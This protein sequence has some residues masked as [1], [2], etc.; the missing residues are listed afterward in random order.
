[1]FVHLTTTQE[2]CIVNTVITEKL[3]LFSEQTDFVVVISSHW[4]SLESYWTTKYLKKI[5]LVC[6]FSSNWKESQF[7]ISKL[8]GT[9]KDH[10]VAPHRTAQKPSDDNSLSHILLQKASVSNWRCKA[11]LRQHRHPH[12]RLVQRS[13]SSAVA[14]WKEKSKVGAVGFSA[15]AAW[16]QLSRSSIQNWRKN[17]QSRNVPPNSKLLSSTRLPGRRRELHPMKR[18][19][20]QENWDR[21]QCRSFQGISLNHA[22]CNSPSGITSFCFADINEM[23]TC[24]AH[25][26]LLPAQFSLRAWHRSGCTQHPMSR[27]LRRPQAA[28]TGKA[29]LSLCY[30]KP[31]ATSHSQLTKA[32]FR[33]TQICKR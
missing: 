23:K 13:V 28:S 10:W 12:T 25:L 21:K 33:E 9:H 32:R 20:G 11:L 29:E 27:V 24:M 3:L 31:W 14:G 5:Y 19:H 2:K 16:V 17:L 4:S 7:S 15:L 22:P 1:M 6:V 18:P 8:E 30:F 26:C